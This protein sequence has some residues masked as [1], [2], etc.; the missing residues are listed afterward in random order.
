MAGAKFK[1]TIDSGAIINVIDHN[2]FSKIQNITITSTKTKAFAHDKTSLFRK[3]RRCHRKK[4]SVASFYVT[5][6]EN[7]GDLLLLTKEF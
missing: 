6:A 2:T 7:C 4:N 3:I 5:K 1:T